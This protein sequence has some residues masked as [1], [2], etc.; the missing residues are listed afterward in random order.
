MKR[1]L[2]ERYTKFNKFFKIIFFACHSSSYYSFVIM[3][4]FS[5]EKSPHK[6]SHFT[7]NFVGVIPYIDRNVW[8]ILEYIYLPYHC[9][10]A[11]YYFKSIYWKILTK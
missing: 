1:P 10:W 3:K 7:Y 5:L 4:I 2:L 9:I 6:V 11:Q 8:N